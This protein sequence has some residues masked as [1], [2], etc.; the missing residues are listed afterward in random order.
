M[1]KLLYE[2]Q[3]VWS[4]GK[5]SWSR[6]H[7]NQ[8]TLTTVLFRCRR[9]V[10]GTVRRS[11]TLIIL[12]FCIRSPH[13]TW[14]QGDKS[15]T[16]TP[17]WGRHIH[18]LYCTL[19]LKPCYCLSSPTLR[20]AVCHNH[21]KDLHRTQDNG[22]KTPRGITGNLV[23]TRQIFLTST[24]GRMIVPVIRILND[25]SLPHVTDKPR[26]VLLRILDKYCT[27][28]QVISKTTIDKCSNSLTRGSHTL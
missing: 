14:P 5:M 25:T 18:G 8:V 15:L 3:I 28:L 17:Q 1:C 20:A 13:A 6:Q 23:K 2:P 19:L 16:P 4:M 7:R 11:P 26:N 22:I 27:S 10:S 12:I 21:N 9:L 24:Q